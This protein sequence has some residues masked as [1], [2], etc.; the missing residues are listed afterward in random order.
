M[1][2]E[3]ELIVVGYLNGKAIITDELDRMY[4]LECSEN[5]A[6]IGTVV[7][8]NGLHSVAEL[9]DSERMQIEKIFLEL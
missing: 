6:P 1:Q 5:E 7:T 2:T 9:E 8:E 3:R 4:Y